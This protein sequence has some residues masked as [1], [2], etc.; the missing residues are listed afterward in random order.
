VAAIAELVSSGEPVLALC[1]DARRRRA[2]AGSAADPRRFGAAAP[3]LACCRCGDEALESAFGAEGAGL[4]LADWGAVARSPG[5][6]ARFAHVV[7]V[8][9]PPFE[10]LDE[11]ARIGP[12]YLH[13]AWGQPEADLAERCLA[14]EWEPRGAVEQV[15]R[16]LIKANGE[17]AGEELRALLAGPSEFPRTPEVAARAIAVLDELGLCEWSGNGAAPS[18]RVLS[19]ERTELQRSRAYGACVARHEEGKRFLRSR[20]Q[21]S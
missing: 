11:L 15:W 1:V 5:S 8:D 17:A 6:V 12:G 2:L 20:A 16:L 21:S 13:L 18:L 3:V 10:Q 4:V 7:M 19:S 14:L 9:P